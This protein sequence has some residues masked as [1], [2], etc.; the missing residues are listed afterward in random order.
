MNKDGE[1]VIKKSWR[2]GSVSYLSLL[3]LTPLYGTVTEDEELKTAEKGQIYGFVI[4]ANFCSTGLGDAIYNQLG[5]SFFTILI[6]FYS[7]FDTLHCTA[8]H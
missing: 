8:L 7:D 1:D 3:F 6:S 2:N 5:H 4:T